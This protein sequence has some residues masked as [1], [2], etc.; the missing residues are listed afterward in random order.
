MSTNIL[1]AKD[2]K[3]EAHVIDAEDQILGRLATTIATKLSG[4]DKPSYV[5]YLDCGDFVVVKNAA[6]IKVT[7]KK[8]SQKRYVRHSGYSGGLKVEIFQDLIKRR[9]EAVIE[10]AVRGMLPKT[11]L[12][13]V[14]IKKLKVYGGEVKND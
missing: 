8:A 2:I 7:G 12:G 14:M 10:H 1:S 13:R 9:P 6:K 3:R 5:P 11:K 4:K